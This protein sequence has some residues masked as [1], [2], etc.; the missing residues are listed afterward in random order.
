MKCGYRIISN[1]KYITSSKYLCYRSFSTILDKYKDVQ[2]VARVIFNKHIGEITSIAELGGH[3]NFN[4]KVTNFNNDYIIKIFNSEARPFPNT[5]PFTNSKLQGLTRINKCVVSKKYISD[6]GD[7]FEFMIFNYVKGNTVLQEITTSDFDNA[8]LDNIIKQIYGFVVTCNQIKLK[9]FGAINQ[10]GVGQ[11]DLWIDFLSKYLEFMYKDIQD[12]SINGKDLLYAFH[13]NLAYFL[14]RESGYFKSIEQGSLVPYDLN[15]GNFILTE[16]DQ[17]V[18]IDTESFVSGDKLLPFGVWASNFYGTKVYDYFFQGVELH[19]NFEHKV[20]SFYS[21]LKT[22]SIL[23]YV[24]KYREDDVKLEK[25]R[26]NDTHTFLSIMEICMSKMKEGN[27]KEFKNMNDHTYI[28]SP[29]EINKV[30]VLGQDG[31]IEQID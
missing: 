6:L 23:I 31:I 12:L 30:E 2:N 28:Q 27:I 17:V 20:I 22:L 4:Y 1:L 25:P 13:K 9:N 5:E 18:S 14:Q 7:E 3:R 24:A 19:T 11:S 26:G 10:F 21:A 29:T 15:L 8:R 16:G